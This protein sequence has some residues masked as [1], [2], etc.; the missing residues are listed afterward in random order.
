MTVVPYSKLSETR[1]FINHHS[2][3]LL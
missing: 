2:S 3:T 1:C